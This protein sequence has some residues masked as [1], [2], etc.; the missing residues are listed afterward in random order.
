MGNGHVVNGET[1]QI[2]DLVSRQFRSY[3]DCILSGKAAA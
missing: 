1:A 3:P 2:V